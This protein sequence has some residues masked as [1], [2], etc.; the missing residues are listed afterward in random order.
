MTLLL[1]LAC[2]RDMPK[3]G[4]DD[5]DTLGGARLVA[6]PEALDWGTLAES[7]P[8]VRSFTLE[9]QG[10]GAAEVTLTVDATAAWT[11]DSPAFTLEEGASREVVVTF[12]GALAGTWSGVVL[13][14]PADP[15][16]VG[17]PSRS[18]R[19]SRRMPMATG[20]SPGATA[21]TPTRR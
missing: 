1:L 21:M 12:P 15:E 8:G 6:T 18:R 19:A 2:S 10:P 9:N 11:V 4:T 20:S 7:E 16:S 5:P 13:A 14:A 3:A 17:A